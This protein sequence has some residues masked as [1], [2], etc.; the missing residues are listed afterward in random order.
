[1]R[2]L[3]I[4]F[5]LLCLTVFSVTGQNASTRTFADKKASSI[6]YSMKHPLH[7]WSGIS[8][9]VSSL[10][11]SEGKKGY[12]Q[13]VAVSVKV[14]SFDSK[15]A[16]RD[17]HMIEVTEAIKFPNITFS[18]KVTSWDGSLLTVTGELTFH[19]VTRPLSFEVKT[20]EKGDKL[21]V[22]GGFSVNLTEFNIQRPT[23]MG[24]PTN[25]EIKVD[26][27]MVY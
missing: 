10:I 7:N 14:S 6:T 22:T 9:D 3:V 19:G 17:S 4:L 25:D 23:L 15:N 26:F 21:E 18:G 27:N 24:L 13:E 20:A 1:M 8:R 5:I 12:I 2:N 11:V 16:N